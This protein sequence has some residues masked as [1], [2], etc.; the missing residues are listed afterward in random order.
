M[1]TRDLRT[2][3]SY[4]TSS[5]RNS[6]TRAITIS[7][8]CRSELLKEAE[9]YLDIHNTAPVLANQKKHK[10]RVKW[11][12]KN[13]TKFTEV[14][15]KLQEYNT[16]LL[17]LLDS[18][19]EPSFKTTLPGY[20][21]ALI[22]KAEDLNTIQALADPA[23]VLVAHAARLK[24]LEPAAGTGPS[25]SVDMLSISDFTFKD[26]QP[27]QQP[28]SRAIGIYNKVQRTLRAMLSVNST[29]NMRTAQCI[30]VLE[31]PINSLRL[32]LVFQ[33]PAKYGIIQPTTL[34]QMIE[35][36]T[37]ESPPKSLLSAISLLLPWLHKAFR[38]DNILFFGRPGDPN[39]LMDSYIS[40]FENSREVTG[41]SLGQG[42]S[43]TMDLYSFGVVF[44]EIA[45]WRPL[46][47]K[48]AKAKAL[49][50]LEA[51]R[52]V[53]VASARDNLPAMVGSIY[54]EVV[55]KCLE[56]AFPN[57]SDDELA[58]A[59]GSGLIAES[60]LFSLIN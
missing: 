14:V 9:K 3:H 1:T 17:E 21:L 45:Y 53:T 56:C 50:S 18:E 25:V 4:T 40:G 44:L 19:T 31:D 11:A 51:T 12:I 10:R 16:K 33:P 22:D 49:G 52:K 48:I 6:S 13:K 32:G 23:N 36:S 24:F 54:A 15:T 5:A 42:F 28:S 58:C 37:Q 29:A 47:T 8:E 46:R 34:L 59:V 26:P 2:L 60:G 35:G 27:S 55:M 57:E 38:S 41:E 7:F 39:T 20:I 30:G 43:K